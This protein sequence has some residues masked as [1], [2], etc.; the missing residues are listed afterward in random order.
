MIH[1]EVE[2]YCHECSDFEADVR[3][4]SVYSFNRCV[5]TDTTVRCTHRNRCEAIFRYL[6]REKNENSE[7]EKKDIAHE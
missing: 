5:G 6:E 2:K 1:L 4:E 3:S 7:D